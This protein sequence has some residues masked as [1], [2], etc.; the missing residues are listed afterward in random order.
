[1]EN[2]RVSTMTAIG[3]LNN[4]IDLQ[5]LYNKI[6][7]ND[8]IKYINYGING[9]KGESNKKKSKKKVQNKKV[10]YNQLTFHIFYDKIIN[11]KIFN[12][13]KIQMTGIKYYEQGK[14]VINLLIKQ[15]QLLNYDD[16]YITKNVPISYSNY[17]IVLIN[18]DFDIKYEINREILHKE[19]IKAGYYSSFEPCI[20]PG[21]NIKYYYNKNQS[22]GICI[23]NRICNGKGKGDYDG[24]CKKITIAVFASGKII[25]TGAKSEPQLVLSYNFI[26]DFINSRK[27]L[28]ELK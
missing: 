2:L 5:K 16:I 8:I 19:I 7:P 14:H 10:F 26:T 21:V 12:N 27:S 1:M 13:G 3:S 11:V 22:N 15:L 9:Y 24:G 25:I 18:S 4:H 6:E 17:E 20:Y 28:F 23:C